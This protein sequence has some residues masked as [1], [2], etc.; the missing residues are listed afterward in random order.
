MENKT[1]KS[2]VQEKDSIIIKNN[3]LNMEEG[4][5]SI[6]VR[7]NDFVEK[8][9]GDGEKDN[10]KVCNGKEVNHGIVDELNKS[11][12]RSLCLIKQIDNRLNEL[13]RF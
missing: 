13:E 7:I 10:E 9:Y 6:Y 2:A 3:L 11:I 4:L 8:M 12:D 5:L 1:E